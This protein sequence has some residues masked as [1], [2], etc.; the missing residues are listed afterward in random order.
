VSASIGQVSKLAGVS[1]TTVSRVLR[2]EDSVR[3]ETRGKVL[4]VMRELEYVPSP[5]ARALRSGDDLVAAGKK[6]CA[7]VYGRDTQTAD[8]FFAGVTRGAEKAAAEHG[9]CLLQSSWQESFDLSWPRMQALFSTAGL[10][11]AVLA[12]NFR[13][14]EVEAVMNHVGNVVIIDSPAPV[15]LAVGCA[16]VDYRDGCVQIFRHLLER[17]ARRILVAAYK[18]PEHYFSSSVIDAVKIVRGDAERMEV[19][20]ADYSA[21]AGYETV[22]KIFAGGCEY[23]AIWGNDEFALGALRALADLGIGVPAQVKVAGY[24]DIPHGPFTR[25]ALTTVRV[26]KELLGYEGVRIL[27]ESAKRGHPR[28]NLRTV[29]RSRL[30]V[31]EST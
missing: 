10:C 1:K 30:V 31:R 11:G 3:A 13:R 15:G 4:A 25:P 16:E 29:V 21:R 24:D 8:A 22:K 18:S 28:A 7:L 6:L 9:L 26:D 2:G 19:I 5:A 12:G 14:D 17:G 23:D 20:Y 27:I